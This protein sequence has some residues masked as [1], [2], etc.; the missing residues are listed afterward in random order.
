MAYFVQQTLIFAI[1]LMIV[2]LAGVYAERSGI[3]NIALEGINKTK[4]FFEYLGLPTKLSGYK[5]DDSKLEIMAKDV[6]IFGPVGNLV[7]LNTEDVVNIY[8]S[9]L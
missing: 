2:A 9:A 4:E 8:K 7:K 3:I 1:P 6:T 5:I